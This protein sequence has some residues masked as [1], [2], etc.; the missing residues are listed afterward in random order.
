[1]CGGD[2]QY[3]YV[4]LDKSKISA[5]SSSS[6]SSSQQQEQQPPSSSLSSS[7]SSYSSNPSEQPSSPSPQ[8]VTVTQTNSQGSQTIIKTV[9]A[10]PSKVEGGPVTFQTVTVT[11]TA[12]VSTVAASSSNTPLAAPEGNGGS[13]GLKQGAIAGIAVGGS[14]AGVFLGMA[15]LMLWRRRRYSDDDDGAHHNNGR[16]GVVLEDEGGYFGP[17]GTTTI[18]RDNTSASEDSR[19]EAFGQNKNLCRNSIGSLED[20]SSESNQVL[21]VVNPDIPEKQ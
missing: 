6:A 13:G 4:L 10:S 12:A 21:R 16:R 9:Q 2:G 20:T 14:A 3:S 15:A 7:E 11:G 18:R 17:M 8:I 1:M 5:A 19:M